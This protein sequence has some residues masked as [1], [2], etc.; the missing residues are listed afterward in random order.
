MPERTERPGGRP[1]GVLLAVLAAALYLSVAWTMATRG[2][3]NVDE[4]FYGICSREAM[5][6]LLPYR[7][8]GYTQ[9][10]LFLYING[11]A[12]KLLGFGFLQQRIANGLW[13][14]GAAFTGAAFLWR[15]AGRL[16]ALGY[17]M[18]LATGLQWMYFSDL[19]K[20][21]ALAALLVVGAAAAA[22]S[23]M[24]FPAKAAATAFLGV[25]A[26]GCRLPTAPFF[27]ALWA[28]QAGR[29]ISARGAALMV[30]LPAAIGALLIGPFI[31][32]SPGNFA[33]W[34]MRF[35]A[36]SRGVKDW[37]ISAADLYPV[38]P[39]LCAA[40]AFFVAAWVSRRLR[41]GG[42]EDGVLGA[43]FVGLAC[44]ILPTGAYPEYAAP[45]VPA[46]LLVLVLVLSRAFPRPAW[47]C[48]G[49]AAF[50]A[51]NLCVRAPMDD[52]VL[53]DTRTAA[54]VVRDHQAPGVPY[55][56]SASILALESGAPVDARMTMSPFCCTESMGA[57]AAGLR[58]LVRPEDVAALMAS[59]GCRVVALYSDRTRNFVFSMPEFRPI[60]DS[61]VGDW[62]RILARDYYLALG[63]SSYA[64]FVRR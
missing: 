5:R 37:H 57:E 45:F 22:L 30:G 2:A 44:N 41:L 32:A 33:F 10:P 60:S 39:A 27:L 34:T 23:G 11:A 26:I 7:D 17:V 15:R 56:G 12:M 64:V 42:R 3:L 18:L 54:A 6:G 47:Q 14:A 16:A 53:A 48:A 38:S 28:V 62:K 1:L 9:T 25:L 43:L 36:A 61:A 58:R 24:A 50:A 19:G 20:A 13:G 35:H 46:F 29:P 59:P 40:L 31:A 8:F 49:F 52:Q 51:L 4:G 21:D 63:N 55:A